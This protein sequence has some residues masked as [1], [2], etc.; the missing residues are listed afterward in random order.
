MW[1]GSFRERTEKRCGKEEINRQTLKSIREKKAA[2][3]NDNEA[4]GK[5]PFT[6]I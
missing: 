6:N 5:Q 1:V 4:G 2:M 3:A